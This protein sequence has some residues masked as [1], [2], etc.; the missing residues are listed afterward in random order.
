MKKY[1]Y[2]IAVALFCKCGY[3]TDG[4]QGN[5]IIKNKLLLIV[6]SITADTLR[7]GTSTKK[8][9]VYNKNP[10]YSLSYCIKKSPA[11]HNTS[12]DR[13]MIESLKPLGN[14]VTILNSTIRLKDAKS[15][16]I[17]EEGL[18]KK[19]LEDSSEIVFGIFNTS[20]VVFNSEKDKALFYINIQCGRDCGTGNLVF[21]NKKRNDWEIEKIEK[22]WD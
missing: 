22:C 6:D 3:T 7:Y 20:P 12:S 21:F 1:L 9:L 18:A 17:I 8:I 4:Q 13:E 19:Y 11:D 15:D 16:L 5:D 10:D 2:L 14:E